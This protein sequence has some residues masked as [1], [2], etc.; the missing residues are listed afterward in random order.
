MKVRDKYKDFRTVLFVNPKGK[1]A[2]GRT[3]VHLRQLISSGKF[4]PESLVDNRVVCADQA[5]LVVRY[6]DYTPY[7][8]EHVYD[9]LCEIR[10]FMLANSVFKIFLPLDAFTNDGMPVDLLYMVI[11]KVFGHTKLEVV[12]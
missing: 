3:R 11:Q 10:K 8:Q 4:D 12:C 7:S 2:R 5:Y 1:G 9:V 6:A